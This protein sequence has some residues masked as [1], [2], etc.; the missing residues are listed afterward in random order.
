M[1]LS[2]VDL[3]WPVELHCLLNCWALITSACASL[4]MGQPRKVPFTSPSTSLLF[5]NFQ[6]FLLQR[7]TASPSLPLSRIIVPSK[8]SVIALLAMASLAHPSMV[9]T[10]L[11]SMKLHRLLS[12]A[13]A[14]D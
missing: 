9:W 7:I 14:K 2:A 8:I 10:S 3:H 4:V 11:L 12:I 5:G 13:P 1:A 6:L